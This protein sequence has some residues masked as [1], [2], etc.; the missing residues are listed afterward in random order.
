MTLFPEPG[1]KYSPQASRIWCDE[2][3]SDSNQVGPQI[4]LFRRRFELDH[5]PSRA[6]L[7]IYAEMRYVVF[8]NGT[9]IARGPQLHHATVM[10]LDVMDLTSHLTVGM[11]V[12]AVAVIAAS[13]SYHNGVPTGTPGLIAELD[14]MDENGMTQS[15]RTDQNWRVTAKTGWRRDVPRRS[16]AIDY[17]EVCDMAVHPRGWQEAAFDDSDWQSPEVESKPWSDFDPIFCLA[18]QPALTYND[19]PAATLLDNYEITERPVRVD[20]AGGTHGYGQALMDQAWLAPQAT[21]IS[22][23]D[24]AVGGFRVEGLTPERGAVLVLDLGAEYA[25]QFVLD[26]VCPSTGVIDLGWAEFYEAERPAFLL[27]RV[28]YVDQILSVEGELRW[29]PLQFNAGRYMIVI[30][31]GFDGTVEIKRSGIVASE[32]ELEWLGK[33][34]T[35]ETTRRLTPLW[36]LCRRTLAVGTQEGLMDCPTREQAA[37]I[38]DGHP[39]ARWI[40]QLTGDTR[41]WKY[42]VTEQYRRPAANGLIRSTVFSGQNDA[43][44]DYNLLSILGTRDYHNYTRDDAT[45]AGCLDVCEGVLAWFDRQRDERGLFNWQ[46]QAKRG[47]RVWEPCYRPDYPQLDG[48]NNLF[49]DHSGMGWHNDIGPG[50]DRRGIN[51]A[52]NALLIQA[53]EALADLHERVGSP[54]RAEVLRQHAAAMRPVILETFFDTERGVF[55]DGEFD[56]QQLERISEHTNVWAILAGCCEPNQARSIL[57]SVF[58]QTRE[59]VARGGPYFWY[60]SFEAL[61]RYGLVELALNSIERVWGPML[62]R[63]ATTLFETTLGDD[64][65]T[66]CHPWSG[67]PVQFLLEHIAGLPAFAHPGDTIKLRPRCDLLPDCR[68]KI[69]TISGAITIQWNRQNDKLLL[70]GSLPDSVHAVLD[71]ERYEHD[72]HTSRISIA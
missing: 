34:E 40:A 8:V 38:G 15:I 31:R 19:V 43:L 3:D 70:A 18:P 28:S 12:I 32:P 58:D 55:V 4:R 57:N 27:K 41:Y 30:L 2:P 25:G 48:P 13:M 66:A 64:K 14:L 59:D 72:W 71:D 21:T 24:R 44:I 36:A 39:V 53:H 50:L 61:A 49:I 46:W 29:H 69:V 20:P 42:L 54:Q 1:P 65:D 17:I 6:E 33:F 37:Y 62:D 23:T 10:P 45:V 51:A 16:G 9:F 63:G 22:V 52:I 5:C 7:R 68:A 35:Q 26:A 60:Y 67:P 11:N 56:G 47:G